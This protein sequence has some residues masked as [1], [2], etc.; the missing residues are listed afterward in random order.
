MVHDSTQVISTKRVFPQTQVIFIVSHSTL[1]KWRTTSNF[2]DWWR[3]G[4][5][6]HID[7]ASNCSFQYRLKNL[8]TKGEAEEEDA[9]SKIIV[10]K[11]SNIITIHAMKIKC[12]SNLI[13]I[14]KMNLPNQ[15]I[16]RLVEND[17][18]K[19]FETKYRHLDIR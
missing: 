10:E 5:S 6:F 19:W 4:F 15:P 11:T 8:I 9:A 14:K 17:S 16:G 18:I 3:F 13:I 1:S 2:Y 12:N 7:S